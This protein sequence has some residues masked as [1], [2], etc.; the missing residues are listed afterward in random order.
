MPTTVAEKKKKAFQQY[1]QDMKAYF[2]DV[3]A[4]ELVVESPS[5]DAKSAVLSGNPLGDVSFSQRRSSQISGRRRSSIVIRRESISD[6]GQAAAMA[7]RRLSSGV[8][9][10]ARLSTRFD[11]AET[12][13]TLAEEDEEDASDPCGSE[14]SRDQKDCDNIFADLDPISEA[15][16]DQGGSDDFV[17]TLDD[18]MDNLTIQ[19]GAGGQFAARNSSCAADFGPGLLQLLEECGQLA[20][21]QAAIPTLDDFL[22]EKAGASE[23]SIGKVGEGTFGEA[24]KL[25]S[26]LVL[27]IVPIDGEVLVNGEKQKTSDELYAEVVIHNCLKGLRE[28]GEEAAGGVAPGDAAMAAANLCSTFIETH[29]ISVCRGKYAPCLVEAWE[30]WDDINSSEN[31]HP[32]IFQKDQLYIAFVYSDGGEDLESFKFR[33][34]DEI[35]SM[36]MQVRRS[37]A[38]TAALTAAAS[39][40]LCH[41]LSHVPPPPLPFWMLADALLL[42]SFAD[43]CL[44]RAPPPG[45]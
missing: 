30:A 19:G 17:E 33:T 34:F 12:L 13:Q 27:K 36:L 9:T 37:A 22:C 24:F 3:D 6:Y 40:S 18:I 42:A 32:A 43:T 2:T 45:R 21:S 7:D 44:A 41:S 5:P 25:N 15:R 38:N 31:D 14:M 8:Q 20:E 11:R 28:G 23:F 4:Y 26:N 10:A 16:E 29:D 39:L 1:L 35:R